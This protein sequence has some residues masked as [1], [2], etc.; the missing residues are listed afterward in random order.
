MQHAHVKRKEKPMNRYV[1]EEF[2]N[3]PAA[4]RRRL[5]GEAHRERSRAIGAAFS[6]LLGR[7]AWL[8][9]VAR[10]RLTPRLRPARWLARLG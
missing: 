1:M 8:L 7:P 5:S 9:G 2:Y 6:W 3:D 10:K 4:L